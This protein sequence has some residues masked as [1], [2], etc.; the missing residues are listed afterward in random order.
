M[1]PHHVP[2]GKPWPHRLLGG[3]PHTW[4][5]TAEPIG[6]PASCCWGHSPFSPVLYLEKAVRGKC[7]GVKET[8]DRATSHPVPCATCNAES[9]K[10]QLQTV[11]SHTGPQGG[12]PPQGLKHTHIHSWELLLTFPRLLTE[13][14]YY[15]LHRLMY[16][17]RFPSALVSTPFPAAAC[18]LPRPLPLRIVMGFPIA[19]FWVLCFIP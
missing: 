13:E 17:Q 16:W 11:I 5:P 4:Q 12:S 9:D 19:Y 18:P 15:R 2:P 8:T 14:L 7:Q 6:W 3:G 10:P 1:T